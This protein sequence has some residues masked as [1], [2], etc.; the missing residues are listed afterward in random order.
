MSIT[1]QGESILKWII[2][3]MKNMV[4]TCPRGVVAVAVVAA[5]AVVVVDVDLVVTWAMMEDG[6]ADVVG[7]D[8]EM[9]EW[10]DMIHVVLVIWDVDREVVVEAEAVARK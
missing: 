3:T 7:Q 6:V 9:E 8:P 2:S 1:T 5:A 10:G 4:A